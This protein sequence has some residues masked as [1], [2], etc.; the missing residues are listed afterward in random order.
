MNID[1]KLYSRDENDFIIPW[2]EKIGKE[3]ITMQYS[4]HNL[5]MCL[6]DNGQIDWGHSRIYYSDIPGNTVLIENMTMRKWICKPIPIFFSRFQSVPKNLNDYSV[7]VV[8]PEISITRK[9]GTNDFTRIFGILYRKGQF[10]DSLKFSPSDI[11]VNGIE[12]EL[13]NAFSKI[14]CPGPRYYV[15]FNTKTCLIA[16][17]ENHPIMY[18]AMNIDGEERNTNNG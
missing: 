17:G 5:F 18:K 3:L 14:Y 7:A 10:K 13:C 9:Y 12:R 11:L 8:I 15:R 16:D 1:I 4:V 2:A 6:D